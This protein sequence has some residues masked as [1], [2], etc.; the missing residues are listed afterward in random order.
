[1]LTQ[2][3]NNQ[4]KYRFFGLTFYQ[5]CSLLMIFMLWV[6]SSCT[7]E[8]SA[9]TTPRFNHVVIYVSDMDRSVAFYRDAIGLDIHREISEL[10]ILDE[11]SETREPVHVNMTLMRLPGSRFIFELIENP[12]AYEMPSANVHFQHIG[13]EVTDIESSLNHAIAHG[14]S[15]VTPVRTIFAADIITKTAFFKGPDGEQIEFMQILSGDY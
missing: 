12:A 2:L 8:K 1:M 5:Q 7:I 14:A 15:E 6:S 11:V 13:I 3:S 10:S 4:R 9:E